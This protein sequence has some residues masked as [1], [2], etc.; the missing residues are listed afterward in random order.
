MSQPNQILADQLRKK[1]EALT[2]KIAEKLDPACGRQNPTR[3]RLE[4]A[5]SMRADGYRWM[6][7]KTILLYL[8]QSHERGTTPEKWQHIRT[9]KDVEQALYKDGEVL[10]ADAAPFIQ[11]MELELNEARNQEW[12]KKR[13][14][15]LQGQKIP[16]FF[17]TP[18]VLAAKLAELCNIQPTDLVLEPSAGSG[19]LCAEIVKCGAKLMACEVN[20]SLHE[21]LEKRGFEAKC[22]DFTQATLPLDIQIDKVL[23]NPPFE[24]F[25]DI[26][27]VLCAFYF[28]KSGGRLVSIMGESA[29]FR[30]HHIANGFRDWL[31]EAD[32][33][34]I[35]LPP[36]SFRESNTGV[37]CRVIVVDKP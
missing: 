27:H 26:Q 31:E 20:Y 22:C 9:L 14:F 18:P 4:Q 23:M 28:L 33:T 25:Q 36:N 13:V 10:R 17:P 29:F 30:D 21:L 7:W 32:A 11:S 2:P 16:G 12:I 35:K 15:E 1:A 3:R 37:N 34:V 5:A 19:N 6:E 8:A 24:N